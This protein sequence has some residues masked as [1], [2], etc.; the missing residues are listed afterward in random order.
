MK[1]KMIKVHE[2]VHTLIKEQASQLGMNMMDYM[3]YLAY[4]NKK[5]G[6]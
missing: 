3:R 4:K 1:T 6:K 5:K 2:D